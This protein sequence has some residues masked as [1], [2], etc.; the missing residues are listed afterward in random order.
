MK[1]LW[2]LASLTYGPALLAWSVM[3]LG[4]VLL[5]G[6]VL[7]AAAQ[8]FWPAL[9]RRIVATAATAFVATLVFALA[10]QAVQPFRL[11]QQTLREFEAGA[12]SR[13]QA[14]AEVDRNTTPAG[15]ARRGLVHFGP[16]LAVVAAT[17][18]VL[19]A[20]E[21]QSRRNGNKR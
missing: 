5:A 17:V 4:W 15:L 16:M 10:M 18:G 12:I 21:I 2:L 3:W 8:C 19:L 14:M 13:Q 20:A 7:G 9:R 1:L 6:T 11:P